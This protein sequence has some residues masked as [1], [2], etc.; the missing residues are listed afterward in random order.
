[1][2]ISNQCIPVSLRALG[3]LM[4]HITSPDLGAATRYFVIHPLTVPIPFLRSFRCNTGHEKLQIYMIS[5]RAKEINVYEISHVLQ[6][7]HFISSTNR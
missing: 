7:N 6:N 5:S 2:L 3:P 1:M 4:L